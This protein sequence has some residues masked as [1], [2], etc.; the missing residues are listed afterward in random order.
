LSKQ[1]SLLRVEVPEDSRPL[2][3]QH[4]EDI[5]ALPLG[6]GE[7]DLLRGEES[8]SDALEARVFLEVLEDKSQRIR[9]LLIV[10]VD[11]LTKLVDRL[12]EFKEA[13]KFIRLAFLEPEGFC[14]KAKTNKHV[15]VGQEL[16]FRSLS[17]GD[18]A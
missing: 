16:S 3:L 17:V 4:L 15:L 5:V 10:S 12:D 13:N 6:R 9:Q 18:A 11:A 2:V 7:T 1:S 8:L 14:E